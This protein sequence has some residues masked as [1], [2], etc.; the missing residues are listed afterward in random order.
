MG[1]LMAGWDIP[2]WHPNKATTERNKSLT[3]EEIKAFRRLHESSEHEANGAKPPSR[4]TL[5]RKSEADQEVEE[6][7][8]NGAWW[9]K[10][11]WAF[12]NEAPQEAAGRSQSYAS[13]FH[14]A[15]KKH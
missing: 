8:G 4:P 6:G 5:R 9:T 7:D 14:V 12:L 1:S 2:F 3:Q 15:S 10:S 11:E 13:Q